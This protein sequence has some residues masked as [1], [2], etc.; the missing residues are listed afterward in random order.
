[1]PNSF[2]EMPFDE[3]IFDSNDL[4]REYWERTT[5]NRTQAFVQDIRIEET[6]YT[7]DLAELHRLSIKSFPKETMSE[8]EQVPTFVQHESNEVVHQVVQETQFEGPET[9]VVVPLIVQTN[10]GLS[11]GAIL[12]VI[13]LVILLLYIVIVATSPMVGGRSVRY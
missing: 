6:P 1:M 9:A 11:G 2:P 8:V 5:E 10:S 12:A 3:S 4:M 13:I 7:D